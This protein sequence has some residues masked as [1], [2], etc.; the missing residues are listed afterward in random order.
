MNGL[1]S[2]HPSQSAIR[3]A[4]GGFLLLLVQSLMLLAAPGLDAGAR[5]VLWVLTP[6]AL[7]TLIASLI[8]LPDPGPYDWH[9]RHDR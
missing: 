2:A 1:I 9:R 6:I 3:L 8:G 4:L 5:V 7:I